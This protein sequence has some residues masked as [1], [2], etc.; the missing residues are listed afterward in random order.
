MSHHII[1]CTCGNDTFRY[2]FD[3]EPDDEEGMIEIDSWVICSECGK[4]RENID[5]FESSHKISHI[6]FHSYFDGDES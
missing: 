5:Q 1:V 6:E 4:S 2:L 3:S